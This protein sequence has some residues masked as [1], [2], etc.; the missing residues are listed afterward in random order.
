MILF[1]IAAQAASLFYMTRF[2]LQM[3]FKTVMWARCFQAFGLAFLFVPINTA[4]YAYLPP[5][6]NHGDISRLLRTG[7]V[8]VFAEILPKNMPEQEQQGIERLVLDRGGNMTF[9][10]EIGEIFLYV[11]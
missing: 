1:G 11:R 8:P 9:H 3:D 6:K 10:C 5:G 7:D 4:A 2:N